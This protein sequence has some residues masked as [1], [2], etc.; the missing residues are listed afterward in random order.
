MRDGGGWHIG[1]RLRRLSGFHI[2]AH[3]ARAQNGWTALI[4]TALNGKADCA[5]LLLDAGADTNA[6]NEARASAGVLHAF[7]KIWIFHFFFVAKSSR[8][9]GCVLE[10]RHFLVLRVVL[11]LLREMLVMECVLE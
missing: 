6:T 1:G 8:R 11:F 10:E 9:D 7:C 2:L 5:R 3:L 4:W